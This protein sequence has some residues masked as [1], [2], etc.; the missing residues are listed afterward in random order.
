[1]ERH[2]MACCCFDWEFLPAAM[3]DRSYNVRFE[4]FLISYC[5][6]QQKWVIIKS[7][8]AILNNMNNQ[9]RRLIQEDAKI[10]ICY[11]HLVF[12]SN[13][14]YFHFPLSLSLS[15]WYSSLMLGT[16]TCILEAMASFSNVR[17]FHFHFRCN[18]ILA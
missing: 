18:D 6:M 13:V 1:M 14:R 2:S 16:F 3:V 11:C 7:T 10:S 8:I 17:Y 4:V 15:T 12:I 5:I 9:V